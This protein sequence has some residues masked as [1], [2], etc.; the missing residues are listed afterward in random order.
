M[1]VV[2]L[3]APFSPKTASTLPPEMVTSTPCS[4]STPPK[5]LR[6]PVACSSNGG[7]LNE[8]IVCSF[9]WSSLSHHVPPARI[10]IWSN[11]TAAIRMTPRATSC[12]KLDNPIK[13]MPLF[14]TPRMATPRIVPMI[15]PRPPL[16][17]A[18]PR[19]TPETADSSSPSP[20]IAMLPSL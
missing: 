18:P 19:M 13:V 4:T 7:R 6:K 14:I 11:A 17:L 10:R 5:L 1:T 8:E 15:V 20:A 2:D 16:R 3:P 12:Q 9:V